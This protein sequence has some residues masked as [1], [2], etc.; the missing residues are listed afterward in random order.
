MTRK[1]C[2]DAADGPISQTSAQSSESNEEQDKTRKAN[3][4]GGDGGDGDYSVGLVDGSRGCEER[5][6]GVAGEP[7][8]D[9]GRKQA[10]HGRKRNQSTGLGG[11]RQKSMDARGQIKQRMGHSLPKGEQQA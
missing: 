7:D 5:H 3:K 11:L 8:G 2:A 6:C 1:S 4:R 9:T 10:R